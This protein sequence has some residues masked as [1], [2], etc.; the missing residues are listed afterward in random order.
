MTPGTPVTLADFQ[1]LATLANANL[2]P[3]VNAAIARGGWPTSNT[4][5]Y[6]T[7]T[8]HTT[9]LNPQPA[10]SFSQAVGANAIPSGAHYDGSGNYTAT[11]VPQTYYNYSIGLN[12]IGIT[13]SN[14]RIDKFNVNN[15]RFYNATTVVLTGTPGALVT[16]KLT[17]SYAYWLHELNRIRGDYW[18]MVFNYI[19]EDANVYLNANNL[20]SGPWCVGVNDPITFPYST[21]QGTL[22]GSVPNTPGTTTKNFCIFKNVKFLFDNTSDS[23]SITGKAIIAGNTL[24]PDLNPAPG[25]TNVS[26]TVNTLTLKIYSSVAGTFNIPITFQIHFKMGYD[27][28]FLGP[29]GVASNVS[30]L[31]FSASPSFGSIVSTSF[32]KQEIPG[33]IVWLYDQIFTFTGTL[34]TTVSAGENDAVFTFTVPPAQMDATPASRNWFFSDATLTFSDSS[35]SMNDTTI[36]TPVNVVNPR[37]SGGSIAS[38]WMID[39]YFYIGNSSI[40][41]YS[42]V[43]WDLSNQTIPGVW[44]ANTLPSPAQHVFLDNDLP[45]YVG[46]ILPNAQSVQVATHAPDAVDSFGNYL[47]VSTMRAPQIYKGINSVTGLPNNLINQAIQHEPAQWPVIRSTD[48]VPF[49]LGFNGQDKIYIAS[50]QVADAAGDPNYYSFSDFGFLVTGDVVT[51]KLRL[52][53]ANTA[54]LIWSGGSLTYGGTLPSGLKIYVS[55]TDFP[56]PANPSTY[57]FVITGNSLTIPTDGGAGYLAS[58][59]ANF[60]SFNFCIVNTS[61]NAISYD[62]VAEMDF[63]A[64]P[65]RQF[66][67]AN[68]GYGA[69]PNRPAYEGFSHILD[70]LPYVNSDES[71]FGAEGVNKPVPQ[72]GYCIFKV[73]ATRLPVLNAAGI[74]ITPTSGAEIVVTLGQNKLNSDNT[75]TF[76]PFTNGGGNFTITIPTNGRDTGD[77]EVFWP[78]L[79]GTELVWQAATNVIVEAWANWQPCFHSVGFATGT[80]IQTPYAQKYALSF[81][82]YF[83]LQLAGYPSNDPFHPGQSISTQTQYPITTEILSDLTTVLNLLP[84]PAPGNVSGGAGGT[85]SAGGTGGT[86]DSSAGGLD[87]NLL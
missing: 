47:F 68:Q 70:G 62:I 63:A 60:G 44:A 11:I 64:V 37:I 23:L 82:N 80:A 2:L 30:D 78:V 26:G 38:S 6:F 15:I 10:Y 3:L 87:Q 43:Q 79:S 13:S 31:D 76:T 49:N 40:K 32:T 59:V 27:G 28:S 42:T 48:P 5:D 52:V 1:A 41:Y 18:T 58:I 45:P 34:T 22:F 17:Q 36:T 66:L 84:P 71:F 35:L 83:D 73:R 16:A 53:A 8:T 55:L 85:G 29:G 51:V 14:G 86:G 72:S 50:A 39:P 20:V 74:A 25:A 61:G 54:D 67:P 7:D 69:Y 56:D 65:A 21:N 9:L 33:Y 4:F 12:D 81:C 75:L 77:V 57:D 19:V 46:Q 24:G